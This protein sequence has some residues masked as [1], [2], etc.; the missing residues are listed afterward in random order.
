MLKSLYNGYFQK[1]K[2]FLYPHLKIRRDSKISP[3]DTFTSW[4]GY[5]DHGDKKLLCLYDLKTDK[6]F[7]EFEKNKLLKN[8]LFHE[9]YE[10]N[11]NQGMYVFNFSSFVKD[12]DYY[13]DGKYS[14]LSNDFKTVIKNYYVNNK[15]NY[16]YVDSYLNPELYY[17]IYSNL[18]GCDINILKSVGELCDKPN[19]TKES[20]K[21]SVKSFELNKK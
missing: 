5:C 17:E 10:L 15:D 18:L 12:W 13:Q 8:I 11:N 20:I 1:S 7:K 6:E 19:L 3:V 4:E 9:F 16:V 14:W 2:V 21:I